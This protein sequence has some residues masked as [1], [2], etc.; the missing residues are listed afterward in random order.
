M[1]YLYLL[2]YRHS[3]NKIQLPSHPAGNLVKKT[4]RN[5]CVSAERRLQNVRQLGVS[6]RNVKL[7]RS[8]S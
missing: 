1:D 7:S 6:V 2:N 5:L 8:Q 4:K 3:C